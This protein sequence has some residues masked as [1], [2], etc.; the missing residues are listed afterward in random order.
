MIKSTKGYSNVS[1]FFF[2]IVK[3]QRVILFNVI[4]EREFFR[5]QV[6]SSE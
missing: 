4:I 3:F 5:N 1:N 6:H 2:L